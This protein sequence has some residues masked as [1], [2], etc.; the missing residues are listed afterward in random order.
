MSY[1]MFCCEVRTTD[2]FTHNL[3]SKNFKIFDTETTPYLKKFDKI[4]QEIN[5]SL[6]E[7]KTRNKYYADKR[8]R[9]TSQYKL[10]NRNRVYVTKHLI[11]NSKINFTTMFI[12]RRDVTYLIV[13]QK[14]T[15]FVY[16]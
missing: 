9:Q 4:F 1:F 10:G 13:S 5:D 7:N 16:H 14:I 12:P 15:N 11:G 8:L 3:R 2:N 6:E